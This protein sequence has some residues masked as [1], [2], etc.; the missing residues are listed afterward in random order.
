MVPKANLI[1]LFFF[2]K[3]DKNWVELVNI[4]LAPSVDIKDYSVAPTAP[5]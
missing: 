1:M 3:H 2:A 5:F 4:F